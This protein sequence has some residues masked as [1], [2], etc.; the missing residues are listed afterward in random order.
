MVSSDL[1]TIILMS[2]C[3]YLYQVYHCVTADLNDP[4]KYEVIDD[5]WPTSKTG[6]KTY[7]R[8][9]CFLWNYT[10]WGRSAT[11]EWGHSGSLWRSLHR[12]TDNSH[13]ESY[14]LAHHASVPPWSI[15]RLQSSLQM[16]QL[17]LILHLQPHGKLWARTT[18]QRLWVNRFLFLFSLLLF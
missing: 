9:S 5:M 18:Q 6:H 2:L 15:I 8:L 12:F 10:P 17:Q 1:L 4:T 14:Y 7:E 13:Q 16:I 11:V 3:S